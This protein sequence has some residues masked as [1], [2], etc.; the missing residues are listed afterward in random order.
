VRP[1]ISWYVCSMYLG[2]KVD[3]FSYTCTFCA[4]L[5][6]CCVL[7]CESFFLRMYCTIVLFP[8]YVPYNFLI[9]QNLYVEVRCVRTS[10]YLPSH[11]LE[12]STFKPPSTTPPNSIATAI[13]FTA[14]F[15]F[16]SPSC[17][18]MPPPQR[19]LSLL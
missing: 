10:D 7:V 12:A 6:W 8:T 19:R 11:H 15:K 2:T 5:P 17:Q 1:Q 18:K 3:F 13:E 14:L 9:L 4:L 16:T